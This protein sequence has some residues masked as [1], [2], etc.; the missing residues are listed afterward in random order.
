MGSRGW[1]LLLL[2]AAGCSRCGAATAKAAEELLPAHPGGAVVTAPLGAVAEHLAALIDRA[3]SLPGGEQL[4]E[5]RR[6]TAAQLGFDPL[7][8]EGLLSAGLDPERAAAVAFFETQP[9]TEL[10]AALP[11]SKPELF[12]QT[13]QRLLLERAG[14]SR[15]EG[16]SRSA[17][18]FERGGTRVGVSVVRGYGLFARTRDPAASIAE[19]GAREPEHSLARDPGLAAARNRLGAQDFVGW[20]P[21]G[22]SMPRRYTTR[23]LPGDVAVSLQASKEGAASR[24]FAQLPEADARKAQAALPGG[25]A[26]LVELLPADA[27]VRARLGVA[28]AR[29]LESLRGNPDLSAMLD[30]LRGAD[31]EVFASLAPG[32]AASLGVARGVNVGEAIDYGFDWRRKSPFDT[33]QL[34]ALAE[35]IDRPRLINAFAQIAKT[36]PEVGARVQRTGDDFQATYAAGRGARFGVREID[37]KPVAYLLGGPLRP[38]ELRRT[39]RS[40]N[41]EAAALYGNGGAAVRVDF[42]K[43]ASA[44]RALPDT[45]YGSGPQAYVARSIVGQVIEPLRTVRLSM[46]AES[47]ADRLGGTLDV[48]LVAP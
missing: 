8:R 43:L 5:A 1:A 22:S 36:L 30:R 48:E 15:V 7:A 18:L 28:P 17:T 20:A 32:V 11:V 45:A 33:V 16:Q 4:G 6:A 23:T 9:R 46:A 44:L 13:M 27:P 29:L 31:A 47:F 12:L 21:A 35:V 37:G 24:L 25:G 41:P 2:A 26:P 38:D 14:F 40:A 42:G 34:V 10:I 19:A 39:P 3:S